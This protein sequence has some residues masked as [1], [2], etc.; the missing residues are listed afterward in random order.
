MRTAKNDIDI[1]VIAKQAGGGGHPQASGIT[2]DY[3]D[4]MDFIANAMNAAITLN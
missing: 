3:H 1:S 4:Q 2:I